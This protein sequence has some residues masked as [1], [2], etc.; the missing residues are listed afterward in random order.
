MSHFHHQATPP[1]IFRVSVRARICDGVDGYSASADYWITCL[2]EGEQGDPGD[3][4]K[5]FLKS[6][7]LVKVRL[8]TTAPWIPC[9]DSMCL[10]VLQ[11]HIHIVIF[12][13]YQP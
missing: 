8:S 4:E 6:E 9:T 5:E 10:L 7:L 13:G 12:G 1:L 11:S 3:I 2:Y